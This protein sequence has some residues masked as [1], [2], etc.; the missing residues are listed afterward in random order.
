MPDPYFS[1]QEFPGDGTTTEWTVSFAGNRP[2]AESGTTPYLEVADVDALEIT[3]ATDTT[4]EIQT[5]RVVTPGSGPNKFVVTPAVVAGHNVRIYRNTQKNYNLVDFQNLQAVSEFDLDLANRQL[6]FVVEEGFDQSRLAY[7]AA[8]ETRDIAQDALIASTSAGADAAAA[9]AAADAAQDSALVAENA[10]TAAGLA[11]AAAEASAANAVVVATAAQE[12]AD[13]ALVIVTAVADD[14]DEAVA[15]SATALAQST[16]ALSQSTTASSDAAAALLVA[17]D[18]LDQVESASVQSVNGA[19][20]IVVLDQ[21]D[22]AM[23]TTALTAHADTDE[24]IVNQTVRKT[25]TLLKLRTWL[26][27][28]ALTWSMKQTLDGGVDVGGDLTFTGTGRRIRGDFSNA[29]VAN[30][31][32]F[33]TSTANGVTN[34]AALPAGSGTTGGVFAFN[35]SDPANY[36]FIGMQVTSTLATIYSGKLGTG[37]TKP[38]TFNVDGERMRIDASG[39]VGIGVAPVSTVRT[40]LRGASVLNTEFT[41]FCSN[42]AATQLFIVRNDG[43]VLTGAAAFS[44]Y[45]NTTAVAANAVID[46]SGILQRSTSSEK[47]KTDIQ[48]YGRGLAELHQLRPVTFRSTNGDPRTFAGFI[49]EELDELGLT[50]F[51]E[52]R[53]DD[54]SP[55]AVHYANIVA[56][57]TKAL[58]ET[59]YKLEAALSRI[60]A[61]EAQ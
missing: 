15:N 22:I 30:Q 24:I 61:L 16:T 12:T 57:L 29:T 36:A 50:E 49:A 28:L 48:D 45:N 10:A 19:S 31:T 5:P 8:I 4:P 43:G 23:P 41:L 54:G 27:G 33:Q 60:A 35:S 37:T 14:L 56:L 34:L 42:S 39:A 11:A 17:Q 26:V 47:Y 6:L 1:L 53:A 21:D 13:D 9:I 52:Y 32:L 58:Q 7:E 59:D 44:P 18:A 55:D 46:A 20:G 25:S 51:V 2:D 38:L 3:P 40:G